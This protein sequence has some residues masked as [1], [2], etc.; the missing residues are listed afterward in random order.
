MLVWIT[1]SEGSSVLRPRKLVCGRKMDSALT[2][3]GIGA[4]SAPQGW[5]LRWI[6]HFCYDSFGHRYPERIQSQNTRGC[7]VHLGR[8][9]E[10]NSVRPMFTL[11][12]T[13]SIYHYIIYYSALVTHLLVPLAKLNKKMISQF[14][15]FWELQCCAKAATINWITRIIWLQRNVEGTWDH[16]RWNNEDLGAMRSTT[17]C[18]HSPTQGNISMLADLL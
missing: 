1:G 4:H 14:L 11:N 5:E 9:R 8:K 3:Q 15:E 16:F 7:P 17:A 10:N 2:L 12:M 13:V 6:C 18:L